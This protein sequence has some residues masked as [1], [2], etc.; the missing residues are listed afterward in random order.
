M[1]YL[2][3]LYNR[4]TLLAKR[5]S[6]YSKSKVIAE[7]LFLKS[8]YFSIQAKP[9]AWIQIWGHSADSALLF[10][11]A[12]TIYFELCAIFR[13]EWW[14]RQRFTFDELCWDPELRPNL[15]NEQLL[16]SRY[17]RSFESRSPRVATWPRSRVRGVRRHPPRAGAAG[18]EH[19]PAA[20]AAGARHQA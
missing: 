3:R 5:M 15:K 13:E 16:L 8:G 7:R 20:P 18:D 1:V 6:L 14:H 12:V 19:R 10:C 11:G 9:L 2:T 4:N 17:L